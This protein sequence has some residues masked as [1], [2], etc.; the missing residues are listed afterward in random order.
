[1]PLGVS[2]Y[3]AYGSNLSPTQ[4]TKRCPGVRLRGIGKVSGYRLAFT[5]RSTGWGG[6]VADL[7]PGEGDVWGA[8]YSV[9]ATDLESLDAYEGVPDAYHRGVL[10][11][12]RPGADVVDAWAYFV[13]RKV[14]D[15][16]PSYAYWSVIVEGAVE[17]GLPA[18]YISL[19]RAMPHHGR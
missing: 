2:R 15:L 1:M 19:L 10:Q 9:T 13:T 3:F 7:L 8:L 14:P 11:V 18:D 17:V 5:R 6:G 16:L 4:L 12:A